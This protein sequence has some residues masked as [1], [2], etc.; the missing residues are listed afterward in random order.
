[1]GETQRDKAAGQG[2]VLQQAER[3][4]HK[5]WRVQTHAEG[6]GD[7]WLQNAGRLSR[8]IRENGRRTAG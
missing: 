7:F 1:M 8:S 5:R 4:A 2:E 6:L 3:W